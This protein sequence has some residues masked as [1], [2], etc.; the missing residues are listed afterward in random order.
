MEAP[1]PVQ[2]AGNFEV[3]KIQPKGLKRKSSKLQTHVEVL[4]CRLGKSAV[5]TEAGRT[6]EPSKDWTPIYYAVYHRREAALTHFL[7][8]GGSPDDVTGSGQPP[9]CV[10]VVNGHIDVVRILLEYG[11]NVD[12]TTRDSGETALHLAI[13]NN[14]TELIDLLL[15][16]GP[17]LE[18]H[19]TETNETPLHYAASKSGSLATIV[20]LLKLG[21]K[22]DTKNSK[23]QSPAE[24]ALLANNIQG[25]VAII[26]AA[27]GR[28]HRLVK[29]KEMLLK[30]VERSQNRFSIGNE[31]IADIFSAACDPDST[32]LVES[33]KR[34]DASLVEMFLSKGADPD[35]VT[36]RGERPIFIA[37][38][39][40]GAPVV[41]ALVKHN[42][43]VQVR[44][45]T[46]LSVL[47]AAF[48]GSMAQDKDSICAIFECLLSKGANAMDTYIDGKNLLH[49]AVS[50]GFGYAKAAHLFLKSGIKVN[51]Q[52]GDGNT[53]L[54]LA[55]HS[56]SSIKTLPEDGLPIIETLLMKSADERASWNCIGHED[57]D[58]RDALYYAITMRRPL[59]VDVL[60][61]NGAAVSFMDW[62]PIRGALNLSVD[63]D[64]QISSLIAQHEWSRRAGILRTQQVVPEQKNQRSLFT[65]MFP[66]KDL[67]IIISMGL[68]PNALPKS[69]LG[70]SMLWAV[71][72]QVPLQP[73]LPPA[74]LFDTIKLVLEHSA[75]PNAGTTRAGRCTPSPQS[76]SQDLPLS[77]HML[78]FLMEEC[79]TVDAELITLLL[80]KGTEL[81]LAS[82]FYDGRYP[83]HSAAKANR[84]DLVD[85]FLLQRADVNCADLEDRTPLFIAAKQGFSDIVNAL[86]SRHA[87]VN[88]QDK[89]G[90]T[91][92]HM[93]ACGGSKTVVAAL[94][95][96][97]AKANLKN[98]KNQTPL[99]C[100]SEDQFKEKDKIVYML[101]DAEQKEKVV[102]EQTRKMNAQS[103]AQ[104]AKMKQQIE[105]DEKNR[106][107]R[108]R[109]EQ[110]R[111]AKESEKRVS[112]AEQPL[113]VLDR[114]KAVLNGKTGDKRNS[115][116]AEL[117]DWL[118]L[119]K[120]M[121]GL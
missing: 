78:T 33:I 119:S 71:L 109:E 48:E 1:I 47:Q 6:F 64:K 113:P 86:I 11:A 10:A 79:P 30:H 62:V 111:K 34:D 51:S 43:D 3:E 58:R 49:R 102:E 117:A 74:Y 16:A 38:E 60:L 50:P 40:A 41:Q 4:R 66:T 89:N 110:E 31:L 55:T 27:H 72:R 63:T 22:Y 101:K 70:S 23:D 87:N 115:S 107:Q 69:S 105:Q 73:S 29:E 85:K 76:S 114:T 14:H 83:L 112:D 53:A 25:A 103:A 28:R 81:S 65:E 26:N 20:A 68:D 93:A 80:N 18:A 75:D 120:M 32:V 67:A 91:V 94:L 104:E 100:V 44:D 19:T 12:A 108:Q 56:K 37:L 97:G 99:A 17:Q 59:F 95:R 8:N 84:I 98:T 57:H 61:K 13:K 52:D 121:D 5:T 36:A 7:R 42:A 106:Q 96:A 15:E 2:H 90:D 35:R 82:P 116:A 118:A 45:A 92:L 24:S 54:H 46:G 77:M 9:L 21:A 39:C 88:L